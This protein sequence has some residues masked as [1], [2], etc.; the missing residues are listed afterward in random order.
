MSQMFFLSIVFQ[1]LLDYKV[2]RVITLIIFSR[3]LVL[4]SSFPVGALEIVIPELLQ[5]KI[6]QFA[7]GILN[8]L[9]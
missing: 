2:S 6:V 7:P 9:T 4:H 1:D 3:Q 5:L 8:N